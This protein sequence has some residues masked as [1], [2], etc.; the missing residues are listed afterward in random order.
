MRS[1]SSPGRRNDVGRGKEHLVASSRYN[2]L[3]P[4]SRH[5]RRYPRHHTRSEVRRPSATP[6]APDSYT[7][8]MPAWE[9]EQGSPPRMPQRR[10]S[11]ERMFVQDKMQVAGEAH[12]RLGHTGLGDKMTRGH[13][14]HVMRAAFRHARSPASAGVS[15]TSGTVLGRRPSPDRVFANQRT[16]QQV[17][18]YV[19]GGPGRPLAPIG[20]DQRRAVRYP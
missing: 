17:C 4:G 7:S 6:P 9:A 10:H 1:S 15:G 11:L 14:N 20:F 19:P 8:L 18:L 16:G 13:C 2:I 5:K 12:R 3:Q